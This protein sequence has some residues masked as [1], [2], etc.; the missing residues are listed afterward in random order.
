MLMLAS[1]VSGAATS[2]WSVSAVPGSGQDDVLLGTACPNGSDCVAVGVT[3]GDLAAGTTVPTPIVDTWNGS[4]WTYGTGAPL[5]SGLEGGFFGVSC[6]NAADCWAVGT[7][8]QAG[9]GGNSTGA[10][11]ENWNG[12]AWSVVSTPTPSGNGAVGAFLQGVT[13]TSSS[14]CVAVGY[15]TDSNGGNLNDLIL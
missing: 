3:L 10:L 12:Q 7:E 5:P 9:G 13:C 1:T 11:V 14:N 4:S 6:L 15:T 8:T 2:G